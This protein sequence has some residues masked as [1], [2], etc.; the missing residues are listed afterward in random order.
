MRSRQGRLVWILQIGLELYVSKVDLVVPIDFVLL[1]D[2]SMGP[3]VCIDMYRARIILYS[4]EHSSHYSFKKRSRP[5]SSQILA[6]PVKCTRKMY[7]NV[8]PL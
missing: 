3:R 2:F 1:K 8:M 6:I 5:N 4:S 7:L